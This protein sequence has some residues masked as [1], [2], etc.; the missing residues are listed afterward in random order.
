[1]TAF[2]IAADGKLLPPVQTVKTDAPVLDMIVAVATIR[3]DTRYIE[4]ILEA[5][6]DG[7]LPRPR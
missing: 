4:P 1:M 3:G 7:L 5:A 2:P 6:L